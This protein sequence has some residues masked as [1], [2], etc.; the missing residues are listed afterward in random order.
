MTDHVSVTP[1][2]HGGA[3][4]ALIA[5]TCKAIAHF[6]TDAQDVQLLTNWVAILSGLA[7]ISFI[8]WQWYRQLKI[9]RKIE[10]ADKEKAAT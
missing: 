9:R 3:L 2:S 6:L 4:L 8:G 1:T 10:Q 5:L 7:S